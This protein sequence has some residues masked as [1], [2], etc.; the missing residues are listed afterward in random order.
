M[1]AL[2]VGKV[3]LANFRGG[4]FVKNSQR[5]G[6]REQGKVP[7]VTEELRVLVRIREDDVLDDKFDVDNSATRV[8]EIE[9]MIKPIFNPKMAPAARVRIVAPG[10]ESATAKTYATINKTITFKLLFT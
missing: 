2:S 3:G 6:A 9:T 7:E 4:I 1:L 10:N 5:G 8:L